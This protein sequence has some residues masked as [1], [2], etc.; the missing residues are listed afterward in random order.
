MT[1]ATP[2]DGAGTG[3]GTDGGAGGPEAAAGWVDSHAH[4][5]DA[6]L[7]GERGPG[8]APGGGAPGHEDGGAGQAPGVHDGRSLLTAA[9]ARAA[10]AGVHRVVCVGT[11]PG[12][13]AA[14]LALAEESA[15]GLLAPGS[16]ALWATG[17]LHPHDA[18][19]GTADVLQLLETAIGAGASAAG[20]GRLVAVGE[21]GL[22]YHYD[23]SPRDAQ[24]VV[25]A[26]QVVLARRLD[27]A[28]VVHTREAWDDT[29]GVL[30]EAGAPER[31][32]IHCFT[33][34][35]EQARRCLDAGAYLSFSGIVTFKSAGEI[36]DAAV[37]CPLDRM[38]VETDS[39][40]LSPVPFRG[41]ANEPSRVTV[42][43][44]ALAA[45]RGVDPRVIAEATSDN[46]ARAY[47]LE[48]PAASAV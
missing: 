34:G 12:T 25:F 33:G 3:A 16:P 9:L 17:G 42:V 13:T 23:H 39:P 36:R 19:E 37:L 20:G 4:L 14:A 43:G 1:A 48:L 32:I 31:T 15:A 2:P 46:A 27:L 40:F 45:L 22:D 7:T 41:S 24:R 30:A 5:Q 47:A 11:G 10:A 6:Y 18:S 26:G 44:E 35:P 28:L 29:L 21:C 38:L 8:P